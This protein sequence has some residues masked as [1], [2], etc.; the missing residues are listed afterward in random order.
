MVAGVHG[1]HV[2]APVAAAPKPVPAPTLHQPMVVPRAPVHQ[3]AAVTP[4]VASPAAVALVAAEVTVVNQHGMVV[5]A[6]YVLLVARYAHRVHA[7]APLP[8]I[9][10]ARCLLNHISAATA[11]RWDEQLKESNK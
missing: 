1:V 10:V 3:A 5:V 6:S 11:Q 7:N 4:I 2:H 9:R 8:H